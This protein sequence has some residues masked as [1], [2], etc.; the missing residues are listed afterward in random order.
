MKLLIRVSCMQKSPS[1][2]MWIFK[3]KEG[4]Q[5]E[6]LETRKHHKSATLGRV[7]LCHHWILGRWD[8]VLMSSPKLN[9]NNTTLD[10]SVGLW[11]NGRW[12][13]HG[14]SVF[15]NKLSLSHLLSKWVQLPPS[16]SPPHPLSL[17]VPHTVHSIR[18]TLVKLNPSIPGF[19][20]LDRWIPWEDLGVT[21]TGVW[22]WCLLSSGSQRRQCLQTD[23]T[24][25]PRGSH[26]SHS[27]LEV[28]EV[29]YR[30]AG[31]LRLR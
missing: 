19:P 28:N 5:G 26:Q 27:V 4:L 2:V 21:H 6:N 23:S 3:S 22:L 24:L 17:P 30:M 8:A 1:Q 15:L 10:S 29:P 31:T 18:R 20:A 12:L 9:E 14:G 7:A 13:G 11:S 25:V 16:P